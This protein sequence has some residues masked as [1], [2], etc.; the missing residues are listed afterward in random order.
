[1]AIATKKAIVNTKKTPSQPVSKENVA[2]VIRYFIRIAPQLTYEQRRLSLEVLNNS[3]NKLTSSRENITK[4]SQ[5]QKEHYSDL[6]SLFIDFVSSLESMLSGCWSHIAANSK[7]HIP[8]SFRKRTQHFLANKDSS[9]KSVRN[10]LQILR[11]FISA[12]VAAIAQSGNEFSSMLYEHI[13]P[14]AITYEVDQIRENEGIVKKLSRLLGWGESK[15]EQSWNLYNQKM[16]EMIQHTFYEKMPQALGQY[17]ELFIKNII[18]GSK[19]GKD[20]P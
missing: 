8:R 5:I 16:E 17:M 15:K 9:I 2:K 7:Y 18:D 11:L 10:E 12:L 19:K 13:S 6:E 3:N 20:R 1:M 4:G 14:D